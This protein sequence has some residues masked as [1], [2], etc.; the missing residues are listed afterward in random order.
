[1]QGHDIEIRHIPGKV[2]PVDALTRQVR[3][4]DAEYAGRV[5]QEDQDWME[6]VRVPSTATDQER[7]R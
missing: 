3:A 6:A 1:M 5:R 2:N 4:E 7:Q